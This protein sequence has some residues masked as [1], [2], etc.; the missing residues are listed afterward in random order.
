M[1]H[2]APKKREENTGNNNQEAEQFSPT[3]FVSKH[4]V[5][6]SNM[7]LK[8]YPFLTPDMESKSLS[9]AQGVKT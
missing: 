6:V 7:G 1:S 3:A 2:V 5:V 8:W 4:L 9:N